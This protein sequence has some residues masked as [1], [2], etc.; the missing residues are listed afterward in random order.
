MIIDKINK[1]LTENTGHEDARLV[2]SIEKLAGYSFHRQFMEAKE[3]DRKGKLYISAAGKCARQVAYGYHGIEKNGKEIDSRANIIF[4]QGDMAELML[5][6]LAKA[7]GCNI[8]ATGFEQLRVEIPLITISK[9]TEESDTEEK[10]SV[11]GY[12][13]GILL[14]DKEIYLVEAKSYASYSYER[15]EKGD[16]DEA[17]IAQINLY[18]DAHGLNK[19]IL[20]AMNKDNGVLGERLIMKDEAVVMAA[21]DNLISVAMST[22]EEMPKQKYEA[23]EKGFYPWQ[24]LYCAWHGVC[25][26]DAEKVLVS[27]S[28]RLKKIKVKETK[29]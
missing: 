5:M 19:C 2:Y 8:T 7:A 4:W 15:F 12:G 9:V 18:M 3:S 25:L 6:A 26:P 27:K 14:Q 22:I 20:I 11:S 24:C 1:W 29:I 21:K 28:Y 16:I 23:N 17:Y 10:I 13:D